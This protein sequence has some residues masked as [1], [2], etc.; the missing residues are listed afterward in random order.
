MSTKY[1]GKSFFGCQ[2]CV[3][4][5]NNGR[6]QLSAGDLWQNE[7]FNQYPYFTV[8]VRNHI[9][10]LT[11]SR[12]GLQWKAYRRYAVQNIHPFMKAEGLLP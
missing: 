11:N 7:N 1:D 9:S 5:R 4:S 12:Q 3:V 2:S 8:Y 6:E 10:L